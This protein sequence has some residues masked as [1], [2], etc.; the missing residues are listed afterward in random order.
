MFQKLRNA[1]IIDPRWSGAVRFG[2]YTLVPIVLLLITYLLMTLIQLIY[3]AKH[4]GKWVEHSYVDTWSKGAGA[5]KVYYY[6][7]FEG[8]DTGGVFGQG[9]GPGA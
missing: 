7:D 5:G 4:P 9:V 6:R 8:G 3:A 1:K 2:P